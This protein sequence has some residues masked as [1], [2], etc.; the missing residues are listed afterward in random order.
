[1]KKAQQRIAN[2]VGER[3]LTTIEDRKPKI[4]SLIIE[5]KK[6]ND[7][8]GQYNYQKKRYY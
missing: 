3:D 6:T 7:A 2:V 4:K 8:E 5:Q 1:M